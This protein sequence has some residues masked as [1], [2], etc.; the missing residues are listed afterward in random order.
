MILL[1]KRF[2]LVLQRYGKIPTQHSAD[3]SQLFVYVTPVD[4]GKKKAGTRHHN[5]LR[6]PKTQ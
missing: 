3:V 6:P 4:E 2:D 5:V 1:S